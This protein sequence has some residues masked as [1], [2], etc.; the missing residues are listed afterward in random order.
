MIANLLMRGMM[1]LQRAG[2]WRRLQKAAA[3]PQA[4]QEI[5]LR[6]ILRDN[7][8]TAYGQRH[9]FAAIASYEDYARAVPV[10]DYEDLRPFIEAQLRTAEPALTSAPPVMYARTS[11]TTG[12]PKHVPLVESEMRAQKRHMA[13]LAYLLYACDKRAFAGKLWAMSSSAE[14]GRFENGIPFGSASGFLYARMPCAVRTKYLV[15]Y[16]VFGIRDSGLKYRAIL[17]LALA[18]P[19]VTYLNA[20][21]PTT[22][23]RLCALANEYGI[24]LA[25]DIERGEFDRESELPPEAARAMRKR[26]RP[27][28]ARAQVLRALF[29]RTRPAGYAELWPNLRLVSTWTGGNCGVALEAVR[30]LL[31]AAAQIV[32]LGYLSSEFRGTLTVDCVTGAGLP[33]LQDH[34]FEFIEPERWDAG[35]RACRLLHQLEPGR[36]YYVIVTTPSG[37]YRYFINDIVRVAGRFGNTPAIRFMQ[38]G[39]GITNIT[40]EKLYE[41]HVVEA[42]GRARERHA[43]QPSFYLMLADV[44]GQGYR[45]YLELDAGEQVRE[46][47]ADSIDQALSELNDEYLAK[48][49]SGRL[50]ALEVCVLKAGAGEAYRSHCISRG[51]SEAQFKTVTLQYAHHC[52]FPFHIYRR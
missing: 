1:Q 47:F 21:N 23:T 12:K 3:T 51:Q 49:Q 14:E 15:P 38:K 31:P 32:E 6:K 35:S 33:T 48:R 37:L 11:G 10:V 43:L 8:S 17:R 41:S 26:L 52:D 27:D 22:L 9:G 19:N 40:G 39:K 25:G 4:V 36:D 42:L 2:S 18:E 13:L 44:A 46:T 20:P 50:N 30:G 28:P 34:F 45:L 7:Q 5:V 16:E 24:E 29:G